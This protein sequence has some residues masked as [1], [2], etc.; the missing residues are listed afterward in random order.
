MDGAVAFIPARKGS[1]GL[2]GKNKRMFHGKPL[3][4]HSI[5]QAQA[6][7]FFDS[8]VVS[9]DDEDCLRIAKDCGVIPYFRHAILAE[10]KTHIDDVL[11]DYFV[12]EE[13][14]CKYIC[15]LNPTSP[16]RSVEDIVKSY[17]YIKMKKYWSVVSVVWNDFIGWIEKPSNKG[18]MCTYSLDKRPNRQSRGDFFL[19]NG[20]IYW[21]NHEVILTMGNL[22]GNPLK[23]KLYEMSKER[24]LE[25]DD[26]FDFFLAERA[27]E[28]LSMEKSD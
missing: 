19:E 7:K 8:I 4:Q 22:I 26:K 21:L 17:K 6:C 1:K 24:S 3:I 11:Y 9:S 10:D 13:N 28:Y 16:L 2:P 23:V 12:R 15:L 14:H 20:A 18:P 25:I 27:Y 5:E